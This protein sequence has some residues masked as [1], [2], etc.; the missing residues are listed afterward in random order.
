MFKAL[1]IYYSNTNTKLNTKLFGIKFPNPVGLAA[2]LDKNAKLIKE[3][4]SLGFGFIEI[5]TVT[6]KPQSGNP[7]KRLFRLIEDNAVINRMGFN[8]EGI[9]KIASRLRKKG[10]VI[11]GGNIGKNKI[12]PIENAISDYLISFDYFFESVDY[13]AVNV[14]SPNTENLRELQHQDNLKALLNSIQTNNKSRKKPK[15]ILLK[16]ASDLSKTQLLNIIEVVKETNLDGII[17]TNTTIERNSLNPT[18][19]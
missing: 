10:N 11:V 12:T 13:F 3:F 8:N 18:L 2:G 15:T 19:V 1:S 16:I 14:S 17:A 6:P 7:K 5:G 4:S 9:E